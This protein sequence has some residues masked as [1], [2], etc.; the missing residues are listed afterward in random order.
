MPFC[1]A[2]LIGQARMS[3]ALWEWQTQLLAA[4][5]DHA[6]PD[7]D[8]A[9]GVVVYY[10][11]AEDKCSLGDWLKNIQH[12]CKDGNT[13]ESDSDD[14]DG[15]EPS[16]RTRTAPDFFEAGS[17]APSRTKRFEDVALLAA[18]N[19]SGCEYSGV[20]DLSGLQ[21]ENATSAALRS[22]C[23]AHVV[24]NDK[25]APIRKQ[26]LGQ[27]NFHYNIKVV[28]IIDE[29]HP[30]RIFTPPNEPAFGVIATKNFDED[31]PIMPYHGQLM[32]EDQVDA[33]NFYLY[34][35]TSGLGEAY[36]GP[37]LFV[38]PKGKS[39]WAPSSRRHERLTR[40]GG[41]DARFSSARV[42]LPCKLV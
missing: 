3:T 24:P 33:N 22:T 20:Q 41:D 35:M 34:E 16:T 31:E 2:Q 7:F 18:F 29:R 23:P 14:F 1:L 12:R 28:R 15:S 32:H 8:E 38:D 25:W 5:G 37:P 13:D 42:F 4:H 10:D 11:E 26:M 17:A 19:E 6:V 27:E 40:C 21:D 39:N 30:V 9:P 36:N